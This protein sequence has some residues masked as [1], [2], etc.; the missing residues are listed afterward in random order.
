MFL[1]FFTPWFE[2]FTIV[3]PLN[4]FVV[5]LSLVQTSWNYYSSWCSC[6]SSLW[7]KVQTF[8]NYYFSW[9]SCCSYLASLNL[10]CNRCSSYIYF[11][12]L[13]L[14]QTSCSYYCFSWCSCFSS[15]L[16][17]KFESLATTILPNVFV[18]L[19]SLVWSLN[20]SQLLFF[21][22]FLFVLSS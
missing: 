15:I 17:M 13:S 14:I 19:L 9:C 21:L 22:M 18:T 3:V 10:N 2:P 20:H 11:F 6:Y 4:V 1:L 7:F 12:L 5:V 16:G 8:C